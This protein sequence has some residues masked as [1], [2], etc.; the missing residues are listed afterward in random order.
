MVDKAD[1][2]AEETVASDFRANAPEPG[3]AP[4]IDLGDFQDFKLDNG[5]QVILV[6]NHKLP[7]VSYQLFIDVP[8]HMEGAYAG[9]SGM[10]G[11]MLRRATSDMTKSEIDEAI[12]FIGANL[13]TSGS[14]AFASTISKY[15]MQMMEMMG[16]VILDAQF[17]EEEFTKVKDDAIAGLK[18]AL[19]DPNAI[20]GRVRRVLNYGTDHPY[21][22]L[23][24]EETLKNV[25][26]DVVK[27][28]YN[29]YFVPNRSYLVMV[30]DLTRKE[31]E[32]M[33]QK[34]FGSW[35]TKDVPSPSF[36]VPARPEGVVVNFVPKAG[37]VQS[38]INIGHPL[39]LKPGTKKAIQ[40][41]IANS[42]LGSG[43]SGRLF[44]N[45]REDKG[46]TYGAYSRL[47]NDRLVGQFNASAS[48]RNEVTDSAVQQFLLEIAEIS[49]DPVS[50]E[51]LTRAKS[52]L[53]GS[54]G[55]AL[56]RPR[57]IASYALS[58]IRYGLE[59]DFYPTYLQKVEATTTADILKVASELINTKGINITVVGDKAVAEKLAQFATN[60]KV[61]YF[62]VNGN[63]LDMAAMAAPTDVSAKSVLE[64]YVEAIGGLDAIGKVK[65]Y[66]QTMEATIQGQTIT[67]TFYKA[68]GDKF[69][70]Q[71]QMMGMV[72][73]DQ[74]YNAGKAMMKQQ[75]QVAEPT[76]EMVAALKEQAVLFPTA[77]LLQK[78]DKVSVSGTET[79][80][81]K[82]TIV[83]D[84]EDP[85]GTAQ[86]YFDA[87]S[88]LLIRQV[89]SQGG[90]A[91]TVDLSDYK[92]VG[93]VMFPHMSAISGMMPF[94]LEM[95]TKEIK[96][97]TEIDAALFE[98]EE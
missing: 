69:S 77:G 13:S 45:L 83:L 12:D 92:D 89:R 64:G 26:L 4:E 32:M 33:A 88:K 63:P 43:S 37:S 15:K 23:E 11:S 10:M 67:Q 5:L 24:T 81:G 2:M 79:I 44:Q 9:A 19:A 98:I 70:S 51:E 72:M 21:G 90:Q 71:T 38:V 87:D 85:A 36:A 17:P 97:N 3:P 29:T 39:E 7:R 86:Y 58:T 62:D 73:A 27:E 66:A 8:P 78:L 49:K 30:G 40:A 65:N 34:T 74:R 80:D 48:V 47:S 60:G 56:E 59:R 94:P 1:K 68:D 6:E 76:D 54:F 96:I 95:K 55:R 82:K 46:Y 25:T 28:Y 91:V 14:G 41:G 35:E 31:A 20:A 42:I 50:G 53:N 18:S 22:E 75:G 52:Q 84:V 57:Q 93:G 61:N 16:K